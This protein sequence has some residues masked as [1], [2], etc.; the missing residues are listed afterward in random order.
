MKRVDQIF[1]YSIQ[2]SSLWYIIYA[3]EPH[4]NDLPKTRIQKV[5]KLTQETA[6]CLW[7]V[8]KEGEENMEERE[9]KEEK[10]RRHRQYFSSR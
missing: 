1:C 4:W 7:F 3:Q 9:D 5:R 6:H 8:K 2:H 10:E